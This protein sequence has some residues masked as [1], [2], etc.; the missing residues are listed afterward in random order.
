MKLWLFLAVILLASCATPFER[1]QKKMGN[2]LERFP[3][4]QTHDTVTV[5]NT[6]TV[7][8][9]DSMD[10]IFT[11]SP[12]PE[13]FYIFDSTGYISSSKCDS[14]I[15]DSYHK[16]KGGKQL[17]DID[18]TFVKHLETDSSSAD[19]TIRIQIKNNKLYTDVTG[20]IYSKC[21][22]EVNIIAPVLAEKKKFPWWGY[23]LIVAGS[24]GFFFG[25]A[26]SFKKK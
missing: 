17:K 25:L 10:L 13:V 23:M 16:G 11:D 20:L 4:L 21:V 26:H 19:I 12:E 2:L 3:G 5:T 14:L 24:F 15:R 8:L 7:I 1:A 22:T 9:S 18:T 6:V